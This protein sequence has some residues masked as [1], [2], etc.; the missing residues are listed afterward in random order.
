[1]PAAVP[2]PPTV[3]V[4]AS[5]R[6]ERFR[7]AGGSGHKLQAALAGASVLSHTLAA[8]RASGLPWHLEDAGHPGMGDSI[9]AAVR[10]TAGAAGWLILPADLPLVQPAT[11]RA[12]AGALGRPG[13]AVQPHYRGQR[14]HP[15]AF[16]AA[17]F[18]ALARL[19]GS[20]GAAAV[21]R[22]LREAGQVAEIEVDDV[23]V[24]TDIDTPAELARAEA[25]LLAR[26]AESPLNRA[27]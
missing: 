9:G 21:L 16:D 6:G 24:V 27:R 14:G 1:M 12:V 26:V 25:L 22:A 19:A 17:C 15:V 18:G 11:L 3:I 13:G 8:V 2:A 20:Q 4:L 10:A 7:A 5:G 23:G